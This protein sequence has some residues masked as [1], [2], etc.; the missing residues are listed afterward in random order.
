MLAGIRLGELAVGLGGGMARTG[1]GTLAD[2][3]DE[4]SAVAESHCDTHFYGWW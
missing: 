3:A 2:E 4:G 1:D